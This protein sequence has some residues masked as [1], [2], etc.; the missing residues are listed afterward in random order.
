MQLKV[1]LWWPC[2]GAPCAGA[3]PLS[4][5]SSVKRSRLQSHDAPKRRSWLV[6]KPP[7]LHQTQR[8]APQQQQAGATCY[9]CSPGE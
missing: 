8:Q 6:M 1:V 7:Y 4:P 5:S 2:C 9:T 3:S